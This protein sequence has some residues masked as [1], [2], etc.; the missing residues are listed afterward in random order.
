M[1]N[2]MLFF[3]AYGVVDEIGSQPWWKAIISIGTPFFQKLDEENCLVT[4]IWQDVEGS[5]GVSSIVNV[6]LDINSLTDHHSW[7]PFCLNRFACT[8]VWLGQL[9]VNS[10]WR[11]SYSF[12]PLTA[13]QLP[14]VAQKKGGDSTQAQRTWWVDVVQNQ[15]YDELNLLPAQISG[16]GM[17]SPLHLPNAPEEKGWKEWDQG[18]LSFLS[19]EQIEPVHWSSLMLNNQ[20]NCS[21]FSTAI[22]A[23]APLVILLDGQKWGAASGTLS[24]LQ[25]LTDQ[26]HI[27]P[28][29]YLLVPSIDGRTRWQELGCSSVFW[30]AVLDELL[31]YTLQCLAEKNAS[32][33]EYIIV[34]QSLGGL[35]AVYAALTFPDDFSKVISLSGSFWWPEENRVNGSMLDQSE[36]ELLPKGSPVEKVRDGELGVRH[37]RAFL[38]VGSGEKDMCLYNQMMYDAIQQQNGDVLLETVQGGHDWLSWRSGLVNGLLHLMPASIELKYFRSK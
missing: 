32:I 37:L 11:G 23:S 12:I 4:F 5:E 16:W 17:S 8:D 15:T 21:L 29:H 3:S 6:L 30:Q 31:P 36:R 22:E 38:T 10:K 13:N 35:S 19:A 7:A 20:R 2:W 27:V 1:I 9:T 14:N 24:V 26:Q 34:G 18:I 33:L 25:Y 28:A